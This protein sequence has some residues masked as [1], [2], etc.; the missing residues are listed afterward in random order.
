MGKSHVYVIGKRGEGVLFVRMDPFRGSFVSDEAIRQFE[1]AHPGTDGYAKVAASARIL[2][3]IGDD[4]P[5]T[6]LDSAMAEG[7][8][9]TVASG[10]RMSDVDF[11]FSGTADNTTWDGGTAV[12]CSPL[13]DP[14][15]KI[16]ENTT[17][18]TL[19]DA[20]LTD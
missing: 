14:L 8:V 20:V 17:P 4:S 6:D 18:G 13:S 19:Q 9:R 7:I 3:A 2:F 5:D 10:V 12:T 15:F 16:A 1:A 11:A